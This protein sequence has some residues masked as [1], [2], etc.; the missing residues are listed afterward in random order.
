MRNS[1]YDTIHETHFT[2]GIEIDWE[3]LTKLL[4]YNGE[5]CKV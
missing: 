1:V 5:Y 4:L 2:V 3:K